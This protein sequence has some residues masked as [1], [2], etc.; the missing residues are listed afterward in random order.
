MHLTENPTV[1]ITSLRTERSRAP[2]PI[3]TRFSAIP[4]ATRHIHDPLSGISPMTHQRAGVT[5]IDAE[6][7]S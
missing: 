1:A 4:T 5:A 2:S 3:V 7:D 6:F